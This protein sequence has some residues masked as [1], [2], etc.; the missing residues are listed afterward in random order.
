MGYTE[1]YFARKFQEETGVRLLDYIKQTRLDY[2]K[3]LLS[4]T[5]LSI[6]QISEKLQFGTRNYFTRI[7]KEHVGTSPTEYRDNAWNTQ[8]GTLG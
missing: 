8:G 5:N 4:T 3:I 1:Y 6:Q 2:A 7:F